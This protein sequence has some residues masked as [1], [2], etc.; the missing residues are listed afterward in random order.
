ML[1]HECHESAR[2]ACS[3]L[4]NKLMMSLRQLI[5]YGHMFLCS[6]NLLFL[7]DG[8]SYLMLCLKNTIHHMKMPTQGPSLVYLQTQ[9]W[10]DPCVYWSAPHVLEH[11]TSRLSQSGWCKLAAGMWCFTF[12]VQCTEQLKATR[13]CLY[14]HSK[15]LRQKPKRWSISS[16]GLRIGFHMGWQ[17]KGREYRVWPAN[18]YD[19]L[20]SKTLSS[21]IN[22]VRINIVCSNPRE[23][24][25]EKSQCFSQPAIVTTYRRR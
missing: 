17:S 22:S 6:Q 1:L 21:T 25:R 3:V 9:L 10:P 16:V 5:R 12:A 23:R 24:K 19:H 8:C 14:W 7:P 18:N 20:P 4:L 11:D 2:T 13:C 15:H